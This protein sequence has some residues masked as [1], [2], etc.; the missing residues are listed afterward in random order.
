LP[1]QGEREGDAVRDCDGESD[2]VAVG[3]TEKDAHVIEVN[4][5]EPSV[6]CAGRPLQVTPNASFT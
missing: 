6:L 1:T 3:V 5:T 4:V 2:A